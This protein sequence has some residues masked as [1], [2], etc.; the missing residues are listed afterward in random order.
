MAEGDLARKLLKDGAKYVMSKAGRGPSS[1]DEKG[2]RSAPSLSPEK[3]RSA[4]TGDLPDTSRPSDNIEVAEDRRSTASGEAGGSGHAS[5]RTE[6]TPKMPD[7]TEAALVSPAKA[8]EGYTGPNPENNE[9]PDE[10]ERSLDV[11]KNPDAPVTAPPNWKNQLRN[12]I[13]STPGLSLI[14]I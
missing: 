8:P 13:I 6:P 14:H 1:E 2:T 5:T 12:G 7:N 3:G 10:A 11:S 4:G 9:T